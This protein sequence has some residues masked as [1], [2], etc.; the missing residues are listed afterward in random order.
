MKDTGLF[1]LPSAELLDGLAGLP[2]A[3]ADAFPLKTKHRATLP[4]GI[5]RLS[6]YLTVD[7]ENLPR[8]YMTRPE[9]LAAYLHY[10]L[11]WNIYRQGRLLA[12]MDL[13]VKPGSHIV[14]LG[15]GPLTFLHALWLSRPGMREQ[16][17][18]YLAVDRSE[19]A[20]K[21]GRKLF[22][23][24]AGRT[25]WKV[26]TDNQ[27]AGRKKFR[28]A[29]LLVMANFI[30]E[31]DHGSRGGRGARGAGGDLASAETR[32]LERW[33]GQVARDGAILLVESGVRDSGRSLSRIRQTALERGWRIPAPC[34]H[35]ED[36]PMP[37]RRNTPWCHF[38][39]P[40]GD[41]PAWLSRL[42]HKAKLPRDRASLSFLFLTR[43]ENP[44]V[45]IRPARTP[46]K[47]C[48][49]VRVVSEG[50]DLPNGKR[51]RYG[52]SERGLVLLENRRGGPAPVPGDQV[53]V[54]W[55]DSTRRD[56]KSGA[57][58]IPLPGGK[59]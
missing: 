37:G 54:K 59:P 24:L 34:P 36:C 47:G 46:G 45:R 3:L 27:P 22:G 42:S 30:S 25:P 43:G 20:L 51:G 15:A 41:T 50:F 19:P 23:S 58:A 16:E 49:V 26:R 52:C 38:T 10:N 29:D 33:E 17:L 5:R 28:P 11:P 40:A 31:M 48:S 44:P 8:D 12:G 39:F 35:G 13:A 2:H 9:F 53:T 21:V 56:Q 55:P 18:D 57:L 6:D 1:P 4:A 7:R 32:L 14:D